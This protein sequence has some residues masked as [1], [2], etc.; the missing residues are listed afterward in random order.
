M[1]RT[2]ALILSLCLILI[3]SACG[4]TNPAPT[5]EPT[6]AVTEAP[7]PT[8]EPTPEPTPAPTPDPLPLQPD[9]PPV[10]DE[11][12]D[13][14]L[15]ATLSVYPGSAGT[16]LRAARVA[17]WLLDWGAETKLTDD[18][19]YSAVGTWMD[20]QSDENLRIFLESILSVYDRSYDLRGEHAEELMAD[21]GIESSLYPWNDRAVRAVFSG[22]VRRKIHSPVC[23]RR[24]NQRFLKNLPRRSSA[25]ASA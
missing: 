17:A 1:K 4:K 13:K 6:V 20:R 11:A 22:F 18:E 12:L 3:L 19:I 23:T 2:F 14:I 15:D 10:H 21:A 7:T 8:P 24:F 5:P 9:L 16:S 25:Q